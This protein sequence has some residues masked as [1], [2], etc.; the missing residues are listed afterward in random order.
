MVIWPS[1]PRAFQHTFP[2]MFL[3]KISDNT[4]ARPRFLT[5]RCIEGSAFQCS[6]ALQPLHCFSLCTFPNPFKRHLEKIFSNKKNGYRVDLSIL[7]LL[8]LPK[9]LTKNSLFFRKIKRKEKI[10][11][12][13]FPPLPFCLPVTEF[14]GDKTHI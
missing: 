14:G 12:F 11:K 8:C 9:L 1:L 7:F 2:C 5:A 13:F 6:T 3:S 10:R 4:R